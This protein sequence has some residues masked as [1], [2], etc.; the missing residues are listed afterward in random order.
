M[1]K[2]ETIGYIGV[3]SGTVMVGDPC[4][5]VTDANWSSW[6]KE[7]DHQ[8]G[9]DK[10]FVKMSDGTISVSTPHGDGNYP[11]KARRNGRGQIIEIRIQLGWDDE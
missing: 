7:F 5:V 8:G 11:V 4:Y 6:C 10:H 2:W 3:D 9:F 1:S